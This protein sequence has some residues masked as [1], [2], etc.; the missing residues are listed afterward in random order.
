MIHLH[1]QIL[2]FYISQFLPPGFKVPSTEKEQ[3]TTTTTTTEKDANGD[4]KL[5]ISNLFSNIET[6]N[7]A[8]LLPPGFDPNDIP[9]EEQEKAPETKTGLK[10]PTRPGGV[11]KSELPKT[12]SCPSRPRAP[13]P[14][15]PKI[16]SF[17]ER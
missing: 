2:K 11:K 7:V 6:E 15:V 9:E 13:P 8:S 17:A 12:N 10:F 14:V 16:K 5:D 4:F 1:Y 3:E